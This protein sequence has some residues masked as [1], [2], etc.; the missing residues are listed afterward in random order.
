MIISDVVESHS[1]KRGSDGFT[2]ERVFYVDGVGGNAEQKL[3]KAMTMGG[4]PQ[5]GDPHPFLTDVQV[6]SV[7]A[8]PFKSGEQIKINISYSAPSADDVAESE[9]DDPNAAG[10]IVLS[11]NLTSEVEF[12]DI[13]GNF[14]VATYLGPNDV[15]QF[16]IQT[17]YAEA[18]VQRPQVQASFS[19][20]E[21][22][23]PKGIITQYLGAINAG[24]W[25]GFPAKTWLCTGITAR[26]NKS[27][28]DVEY[29]FSYRPE[30]WQLEVTAGL[31]QEEINAFPID[32]ESG[33]G[34]AVYE[35]YKTR[36]FNNLGLSF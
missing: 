8:T 11:T 21:S 3:Y 18:E 6:T 15:G 26:E 19:R 2:T 35:V 28:F 25:S 33:N 31:T 10:T 14:L 24:P 5:Y 30:T 1:L 29:S 20:V 32:V 36:D 22:E 27:K 9:A 7:T 4:I 17:Q 23:I 16:T 13:E 34:Y 12:R